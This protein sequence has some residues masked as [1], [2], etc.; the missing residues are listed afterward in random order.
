ML[1][2]KFIIVP[3]PVEGGGTIHSNGFF[4]SDNFGRSRITRSCIIKKP[5]QR[6]VWNERDFFEFCFLERVNGV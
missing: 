2:G 1:T 6:R 4:C 5:V 3:I